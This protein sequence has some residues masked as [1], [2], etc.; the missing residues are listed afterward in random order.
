MAGR[1]VRGAGGFRVRTAVGR[2]SGRR[3]GLL[4]RTLVSAG[5]RGPLRERQPDPFGRVPGPRL[6]RAAGACGARPGRGASSHRGA[7]S[8]APARHPARSD[9][10]RAR[11]ARGAPA[12]AHEPGEGR[13][14]DGGVRL[15][16][17]RRIRRE[18]RTRAGH[19]GA[20]G[21]RGRAGVHPASA[22]GAPLVGR[23]PIHR[24]GPPVLVGGHREPR[25][26]LP[27]RTAARAA[28]G[29]A[30]PPV[31][32]AGRD[33]RALRLGVAQPVLPSCPRRGSPDLHLRPLPLAS[34][35]PRPLR[36]PGA[37]RPGGARARAPHVGL[38]PQPQGLAVPQ[39]STSRRRPPAVAQRHPGV[40]PSAT[41]SAATRSSTASTARAASSPTST[42][43]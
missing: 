28:R 11:P 41:C 30:A 29:R 17:A 24:R 18:A 20:G 2:R 27:L 40:P 5:R 3:G 21:G 16:P 25:R 35:V 15:R 39:T 7:A 32:G 42:R 14:P 26:A 36:G 9:R 22:T 23:T 10:A 33:D 4:R 13:A 19:S 38:D 34:P 12:H 43:W 31:R 1:A 6:R 8:P 37:A